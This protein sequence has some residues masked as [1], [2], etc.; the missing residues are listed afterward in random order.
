MASTTSSTSAARLSRESLTKALSEAK[1][2]CDA[3]HD[4]AERS[5]DWNHE[6]VET[7]SIANSAI[8]TATSALEAFELA[9]T[10]KV[11]AP[12]MFF[13]AE[14]QKIVLHRAQ[15]VSMWEDLSSSSSIDLKTVE[16][17]KLQTGKDL[18]ACRK[19]EGLSSERYK[20]LFAELQECN[21]SRIQIELVAAEQEAVYHKEISSIDRLLSELPKLRRYLELDLPSEAKQVSI[22]KLQAF[23]ANDT[24][25]L[26]KLIGE[27]KKIKTKA[28]TAQTNFISSTTKLLSALSSSRHHGTST[29]RTIDNRPEWMAKGATSTANSI[30]GGGAAAA[31]RDT[32][33]RAQTPGSG[34]NDSNQKAEDWFVFLIYQKLREPLA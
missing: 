29:S 6:T 17:R 27:E 11:A 21:A 12:A 1:A 7:L 26:Q 3:L 34:A 32:T 23:E 18:N 16:A 24:G 9:E 4:E 22:K 2:N 10:E 5:A 14:E 8:A 28:S 19:E 33:L 15:T 31:P 30:R 25:A 20:L 13:S